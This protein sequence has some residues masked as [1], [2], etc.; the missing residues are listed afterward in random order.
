[1]QSTFGNPLLNQATLLHRSGRYKEAIEHYQLILRQAPRNAVVLNMMGTA[2]NSLG[3]V[4]EGR[5]AIERAIRLDPS[6]AHFHHSLS[7]TYKREG[8]FERAHAAI[9]QAIRLAPEN[10]SFRANKAEM[11]HLAGEYGAA[12]RVLEP[13][14]GEAS[15]SPAVAIM[16]GTVASRVGRAAE[17]VEAL[18]ACLR[19][20]SLVPVHRMKA[21]FTLGALHDA[22]GA[23]DLAFEAYRAGNA[24]SPLRYNAAQLEQQ[25]DEVIGTWRPETINRMPNASVPARITFIV[26]MPRSG[27]TLVE[28]I[29]AASPEIFAAG[30]LNDLPRAARAA[31]PQQNDFPMASAADRL[32]PQAIETAARVYGEGLRAHKHGSRI[33]LDKLPINFLNL[34]LI[35]QAIPG[36]QV[37]HCRRAAMDSCLSCYFQLFDGNLPFAYS[38]EGVGHFYRQYDR[39]MRH[40]SDVLSLPVM[41]VEYEELVAAPERLSRAMYEFVGVPWTDAA[42]RFHE[43]KRTSLTSSN[44]QVRQPIHSR[45]VDRNRH[46]EKHLEPLRRALAGID[47]R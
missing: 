35:Q 5:K 31:Q 44:A 20:P 28:Q 25:V 42:M 19:Q 15:R 39:I 18:T 37:I 32:T 26:G 38:L 24:L 40:W 10:P 17:A 34:G 1:M 45:S 4:A 46:Y 12:M 21:L 43:S 23:H 47:E 16:F 7:L 13:V 3:H 22:T 33:L 36:A 2:M 8:R 29:L 6:N 41:H 11:H 30:E 14:V 9:D 27:T